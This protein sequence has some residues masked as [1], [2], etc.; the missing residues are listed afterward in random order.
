[1]TDFI[2]KVVESDYGR[3]VKVDL[4]DKKILGALAVN[5]RLSPSEIGR[6]VGLSKDA[7]RYRIIQL[8]KKGI[9]RGSVVISNPSKAGYYLH[10]VLLKLENLSEERE[11]E[12]INF[13]AAFPLGIWFGKCSGRWDFVFEVIAKD[14]KHFDKIMQKIKSVCGK[15][16]RDYE[17]LTAFN[18]VKYVDLPDDFYKDLGLKFE[19]ERKSVAFAKEIKKEIIEFDYEKQIKLDLTDAR[20]LKALSVNACA[21]ISDIAGK[22]KIP[23]DTVVNRIRS[24]V[25]NKLIIAFNPII[26]LTYLK[27]HLYVVFFHLA[28]LTDEKEKKF[29]NCLSTHPFIAY[30][31]K[32]MGKYEAQIFLIVKDPMHMHEIMM[33]FRRNFSGIIEDYEPLL[34]IKDYKYTFLPE[35]VFPKFI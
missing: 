30:G 22:T 32:L 15:N 6:I 2:G 4:K 20:I 27:Y 35:G 25:N 33:E 14:M 9:V 11:N 17:S 12:L 28:N 5:A 26:N 24:M 3:E 18:L 1:M 31:A 7:V 8:E 13:F 34:V 23:R 29:F 16:L 19:F 10:T 21:Q